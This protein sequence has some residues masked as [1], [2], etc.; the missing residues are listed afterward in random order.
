MKNKRDTGKPEDPL[1]EIKQATVAIGTVA[2]AP[3]P[4][5]DVPFYNGNLVDF[6]LKGTGLIY[7]YT[8]MEFAPVKS[9]PDPKTGAVYYWARMWIV[10][11][12]HC[13]QDTP[14]V[15]VRADTNDGTRVYPIRASKWSRHPNEDV[16]VTPFGLDGEA[17][18]TISRAEPGS[19]RVVV[20]FPAVVAVRGGERGQAVATR[21]EARRGQGKGPRPAPP[22][23]RGEWSSGGGPRPHRQPSGAPT[24]GRR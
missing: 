1:R 16:A 13:I 6:E 8:P 23:A 18:D 14:V 24:S 17:K 7:A 12:K 3:R 15:A 10:T 20:E 5:S 4:P 22:V 9:P 11:C 21:G 2:K 19:S